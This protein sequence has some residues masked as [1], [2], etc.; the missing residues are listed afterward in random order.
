MA[1]VTEGEFDATLLQQAV[2]DVAVVTMGSATAGLSPYWHS[3]LGTV[4]RL[5]V[6][7][8][9]DTAGEHG[10]AKWQRAVPWAEVMQPPAGVPGKDVCDWWR[11]GVDL[12]AWVEGNLTM[13]KSA[14]KGAMT[15]ET[16]F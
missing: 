8:D 2:P 5:L 14:V 6:C 15:N 11:A 1:I 10:L 9:K 4:D 13:A 16:A 7:M 3:Y 12:P